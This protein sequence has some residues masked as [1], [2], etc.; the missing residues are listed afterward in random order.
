MPAGRPR[1]P[2]ALRIIEGN[3]GKRDIPDEV[4]IDDE[5]PDCP[6]HL[7]GLARS[8]WKVLAPKLHGA[9]LLQ[10]V[11]AD[12]LAAYC[13]AYQQWRDATTIIKREGMTFL[14]IRGVRGIHPAVK[15]QQKALSLMQQLM[16]QFG[17]SPKARANLGG[18]GKS[19]KPEDPFSKAMRGA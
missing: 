19:N 5:M 17:L 14:T 1:K 11:D 12:A 10:S 13:I 6:A 8:Q 16:S 18:A 4:Q 7:T 15:I 2:A 3:R 9:G